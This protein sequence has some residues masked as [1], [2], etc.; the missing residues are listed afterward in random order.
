MSVSVTPVVS[1]STVPSRSLPDA[2]LVGAKT[3]KGPGPDSVS[4][5]SVAVTAAIQG[6]KVFVALSNF[7][8][9]AV[10]GSIFAHGGFVG[11][12]FIGRGFVAT[13]DQCQR[14]RRS[15][16]EMNGSAGCS[17]VSQ[18]CLAGTKAQS[19]TL[20]ERPGSLCDGLD[21]DPC[22]RPCA[23]RRVSA[24]CGQHL[25]RAAQP[26]RWSGHRRAE[27]CLDAFAVAPCRAAKR[28]RGAQTQWWHSTARGQPKNSSPKC[29]GAS[30]SRAIS[31]NGRRSGQAIAKAATPRWLR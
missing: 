28:G 29:S 23:P 8:D 27:Q 26:R 17:D 24:R 22:A 14:S 1:F 19:G 7:D 21:P 20:S 13:G 30:I 6:R 5:S 9:V 10:R 18:P 11:R 2:S 4:P 3:V 31:N 15:M 25:C 16:S 12:S